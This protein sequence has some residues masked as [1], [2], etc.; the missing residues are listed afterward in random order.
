MFEMTSMKE[1]EA[2]TRAGR[3]DPLT[4]STQVALEETTTKGLHIVETP[5][6]V[7]NNLVTGMRVEMME[8]KSTLLH[9]TTEIDREEEV[10]AE[11]A[12]KSEA[13]IGTTSNLLLL[14]INHRDTPKILRREIR[15]EAMIINPHD[16][17]M[18]LVMATL[19]LVTL[20]YRR[21]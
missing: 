1:E 20:K 13:A 2:A 10:E 5:E 9:L 21:D 3:A 19:N 11:A 6:E 17:R 18:I 8:T 14:L 15:E 7:I 12:P 16:I 4:S